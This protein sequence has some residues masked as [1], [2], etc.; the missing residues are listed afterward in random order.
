M[1]EGA[2]VVRVGGRGGVSGFG[3]RWGGMLGNGLVALGHQLGDS[4][5]QGAVGLDK[6]LNGRD[7]FLPLTLRERDEVVRAK[8][9]CIHDAL[10]PNPNW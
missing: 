6:V 3:L 10:D 2:K 5:Q 9:L 1:V 7:Q 4:L 8:V